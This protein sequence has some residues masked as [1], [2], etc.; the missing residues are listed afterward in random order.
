MNNNKKLNVGRDEETMK[1]YIQKQETFDKR[2]DQLE[3]F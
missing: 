2:L 1:K 3:L